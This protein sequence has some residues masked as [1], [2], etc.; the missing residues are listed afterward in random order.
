MK[1]V[2]IRVPWH[3]NNWNG[4]VCKAP[5]NN[6]FCMM[7]RNISST[8]DAAAEDK[9]AGKEWC[10]LCSNGKAPEGLPACKGENGAF[11]SPKK[12]YRT[13]EHVYAK[14]R[15]AP[16]HNLRPTTLEIPPFSVLGVPFSYLA[17]S[18]QEELQAKHPQFPDDEPAP[19]N[20]SWVYGNERQMAILNW[21]RSH[22][23]PGRSLAVMY[24]KNGNPVDEDCRRLI[25]G[26]GEI[27]KVHEVKTYDTSV[28][29][30]YPFWDIIMEHTIRPDRA[31]SKGFLLPYNEYLALSEE[32]IKDATGL[33][34]EGAID[35][36]KISLDNLGNSA[37][38]QREL[39]YGCDYISD[40]NMLAI[41][42]RARKCV[43]NVKKHGLVG[44][45]WNSQLRWIDDQIKKVK[46][47][48]GPFPAFAEGL[49]AIG[50]NYAYLIEE[51]LRTNGY[52]GPKDNPWVA[53]GKLVRGE[54]K[55]PDAV[56]N[57]E[58]SS[59][60]ITLNSLSTEEKK[61]LILMSRFDIDS[62]TIK[63]WISSIESINRVM[64][65]PYIISEGDDCT[66]ETGILTA[67]IDL[68]ILKDPDI[69]GK[70]VPEAPALVESPID[71]R[72]IRSM[73]VNLL[74]N[75]LDAGDTLL[76]LTEIEEAI[77]E[78]LETI[79]V[80]LPLGLIK[81]HQEFM[82][83]RVTFIDDG[84]ALQLNEYRE[85]ETFI[86]KCF[87]MRARKKVKTPIS[88]DWEN[89]V[90]HIDGYNPDNERSLSAA[91]DQLKALKM[92]S[93]KRLSVLTGAAGTGKTT[94]IKAFLS[95][96]QIK[97]EGVLL[98]APTGKARVRL[99]AM[100]DDK[101]AYTIAQFLCSR[102]LFDFREM[103]SRVPHDNYQKYDGA[104]TVI[105]DE[106][107]MITSQDF[108][109]IL[110]AL[111]LASINRIILIGDP[112]Q[113]PPIGAG[114]PFADLCN[115]L[116]GNE[117]E[118]LRGAI[119]QLNT[120]V[121][122]IKTGESDVLTL[123]SWFSGTKPPKNADGI[124][125][126]IISGNLMEDLSVYEWTDENDL[127]EKL[128]EVL[129]AEL[130]NPELPMR[131]R[132]LEA[133]GLSDID[134]AMTNP[135]VV[136]NFQLL[137]PVKNPV[138]GTY[139]LN[140]F[141]QEWLNNSQFKTEIAPNEIYYADKVIQLVNERRKAN[142]TQVEEQLSNGQ[143]GFVKF[144]DKNHAD[145]VFSGISGKTFRYYSSKSDERESPI[146][147]AYAITIHKSQG[148]DFKTVIVVLPKSGR[149]MSRELIYTALTRAKAKLI[150]LV[151]DN[152]SWLREISKPQ[153]SVLASRNTNMFSYS[154][155]EDKASQPFIEGLIHKAAKPGLIVRSKSE[156]IIADHLYNAHIDFEYEKLL[157]EN[158]RQYIPDF[159]FVDASGDRIIWEHLGMLDVP[160]YRQAW[161]K[162]KAFYESIGYVEGENLFT[163]RDHENGSF[164]SQE[165]IDVIK[166]IKDLI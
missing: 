85:I 136:E 43:E 120:V 51:D 50:V 9:I 30:T 58:I 77:S 157:K 4:T 133:I 148:S 65:N 72:R 88:Q 41:L 115:F 46:E 55:I 114:R 57:P 15:Q 158:G 164:N 71:I 8:K 118:V 45:G 90:T 17:I 102:G 66:I 70:C 29:Y 49:R 112:Y 33:S 89:L 119:T 68:G 35:E 40:H 152:I 126:K 6:P 21:F 156:L 104:G 138:W 38:M 24:C 36:I 146:D 22:I 32:E 75:R 121:R 140:K 64:V 125:D 103:R 129:E 101:N 100:S 20:N 111:D 73:V 62:D 52:C 145:V 139:Q 159:S 25:V 80:R 44:K 28:D 82:E 42:T 34:K 150:L 95:S 153:A 61:A 56:Y 60:L 2:S 76:S 117:N 86:S 83:E 12:F 67:T 105:I 142:R 93:E 134:D 116:S 47:M 154:V 37:T 161:D 166:R 11:M 98:L 128:R 144:A 39:S 163:T 3:D 78:S 5:S 26:I 10:S 106:C 14:N 110:K 147:L 94:I 151:Q 107:S 19:F 132:I 79:N 23:E 69:Q 31:K 160:A 1:H 130:P 149:I 122:T 84:K 63:K 123:S 27:A 113:L 97:R 143:I 59:Y 7:L 162:K 165:I 48:I 18:S 91:R 54:I 87:Q 127:K 108:Y 109:V 13:S 141:F 74:R 92:F 131:E 96:E 135:S 99:A 137:S 53:F 81:G 124:F 155:R 16:H